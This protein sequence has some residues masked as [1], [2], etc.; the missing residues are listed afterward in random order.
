MADGLEGSTGG[1]LANEKLSVLK[2]HCVLLG[3][4]SLGGRCL[5]RLQSV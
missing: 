5:K 2:H 3:G 1:F 4:R